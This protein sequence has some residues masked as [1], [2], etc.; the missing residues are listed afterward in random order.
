MLSIS[1]SRD[2]EID[3]PLLVNSVNGVDQG[4]M[5]PATV[6]SA[7]VP[8]G[9]APPRAVP[10]VGPF[11]LLASSAS[12][13]GGHERFGVNLEQREL[14]RITHLQPSFENP[15][16]QTWLIPSTTEILNI[17]GPRHEPVPATEMPG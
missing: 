10:S 5:G 6:G 7:T 11:H 17:T 3:P 8:F 12:P 2:G 4:A 16:P 15:L 14:R 13:S 9:S 1:Q